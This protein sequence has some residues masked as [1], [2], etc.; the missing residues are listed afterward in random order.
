MERLI[1]HREQ[2]ISSLLEARD[3]LPPEVDGIFQKMVAKDPEH[4]YQSM[5]DVVDD[6]QNCRVTYG[7]TCMIKRFI[8]EQ[9]LP[10]W[11]GNE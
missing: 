2:D 6:M 8:A 10:K 9:K 7:H 3:D 5:Q 1:A 4:S 11:I